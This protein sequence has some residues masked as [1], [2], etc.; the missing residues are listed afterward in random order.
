MS[1]REEFT[2]NYMF[3]FIIFK[4]YMQCICVYYVYVGIFLLLRT[5]S[6]SSFKLHLFLKVPFEKNN[7][8]QRIIALFI[9]CT[10]YRSQLCVIISIYI[11]ISFCAKFF[12]IITSDIMLRDIFK[13]NY[14]CHFLVLLCIAVYDF[15][16]LIW[17]N[18]LLIAIKLL[19]QKL[20]S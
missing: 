6:I 9:L 18:K 1:L 8:A 5:R 20:T 11:Q 16:I 17:K 15:Q 10:L 4:L 3:V 7:K 2:F 13:A 12:F 19:N 14:I